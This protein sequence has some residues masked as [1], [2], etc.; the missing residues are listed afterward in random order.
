MVDSHARLAF[1]HKVVPIGLVDLKV[2][3]FRILQLGLLLVSDAFGVRD[4]RQAPLTAVCDGRRNL[5]RRGHF[6][7]IGVFAPPVLTPRFACSGRRDCA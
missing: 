7:R 2:T 1:L 4:R 5:H 6:Q 3:S